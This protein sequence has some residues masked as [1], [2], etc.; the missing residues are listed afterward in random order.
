[1]TIRLF[2]F[3]FTLKIEKLESFSEMGL[4]IDQNKRK[5]DFEQIENSA[6]FQDIKARAK[7]ARENRSK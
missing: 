3:R 7:I 4:G 5:A 2:G 6:T 1:M